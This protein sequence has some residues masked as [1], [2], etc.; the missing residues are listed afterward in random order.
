MS[1]TLAT[2]YHNALHKNTQHSYKP[3]PFGI[4]IFK[5]SSLILQ[6]FLFFYSSKKSINVCKNVIK[7]RVYDRQHY[8]KPLQVG[9]QVYFW[10]LVSGTKFYPTPLMKPLLFC[11]SGLHMHTVRTPSE[12]NMRYICISYIQLCITN[13]PCVRLDLKGSCMHI[14]THIARN[15]Q[16]TIVC[17][18]SSA[19]H[20]HTRVRYT[21]KYRY[22]Y[23]IENTNVEVLINFFLLPCVSSPRSMC[24][25]QKTNV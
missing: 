19:T 4:H 8:L 7:N 21:G 10:E 17:G 18:K 13:S 20:A 22:K 9:I 14:Y 5:R 23:S 11:M 16:R 1:K 25:S 15:V 3:L 6:Q 12:Q 2:S 24:S